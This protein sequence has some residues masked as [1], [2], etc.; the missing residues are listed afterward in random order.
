MRIGHTCKIVGPLLA[1]AILSVAC[2]GEAPEPPVV[3]RP[4]KTLVFGSAGF[5]SGLEYSGV[6]QAAREAELSFEVPGRIISFPVVEGQRVGRGTLLARLDPRDYQTNLDAQLAE[7]NRAEADYT[8]YQ[9]LYAAD[10]VSLQDLEVRRRNFAV[11]EASVEAA[12][13][14][15]SDTYLRAP[16]AGQVALTLVDDAELVQ[17]G[18]P[19]LLFIDDSGLEVEVNIP[20]SDVVGATPYLR[21]PARMEQLAPEVRISSL[22][23]AAFP[24][25][26][27]EYATTADPVTRTFAVTFA[28]EAGE[29]ANIR[30]GMTATLSLS[31]DAGAMEGRAS[32]PA[33]AVLA[34]DQGVAF[35]WRIDPA[36][37]TVSQAA[38]SVG[39]VFGDQVEL[40]SGL[41]P[42]DMIAVSGVNNLRPGMQVRELDPSS[43]E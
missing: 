22:P 1:V 40:I 27:T 37:M 18:Q 39:T 29:S 38:V 17:A 5:G 43:S 28:F 3:V 14:A 30:P 31:P 20:E 24:A 41:S 13:K 12:Q 15:V 16:F 11:A 32:I 8:R 10:A 9:E 23:G 36:T 6:V 34:D 4:V 35:V 25:R 33:G 26:L 2:G 42:G 21:D 19:V 7:R